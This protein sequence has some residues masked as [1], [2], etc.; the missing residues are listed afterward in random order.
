MSSI[1]YAVYDFPSTKIV[2]SVSGKLKSE[3]GITFVALE[4]DTHIAKAFRKYVK[5]MPLADI[6][7]FEL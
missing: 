2:L 5:Q 7:H 1:F 3:A 6:D 4:K